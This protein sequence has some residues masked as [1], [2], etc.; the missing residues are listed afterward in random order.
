MGTSAEPRGTTTA[1]RLLALS[2]VAAVALIVIAFVALG[3]DTPGSED[4]GAA[5]N[6]FYDSHQGREFAASFVIAAAAPFLVIFAVSLA[7]ALWPAGGS[8][9]ALWPFVLIV[10]G[11]VAGLAFAIAGM[12]QFAVTDAADQSGFSESALQALNVLTADTWVAFNAGLG[13]MML[14]AAGTVLAGKAHPVLGWIALI[15]GIALFIPYADF[16]ALI[17]SGLWL[18]WTSIAMYR[19]GRAFAVAA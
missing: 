2:G 6:A 19:R 18:I 9:R 16:G 5:V 17:V 11:G 4:S 7:L 10:G 14:G 13:V 8:S 3:G 1:G 12:M 15:A